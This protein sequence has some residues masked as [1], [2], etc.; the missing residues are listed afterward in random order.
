MRIFL[1]FSIVLL[2]SACASKPSIVYYSSAS[3]DY[4]QAITRK[5]LHESQLLTLQI[6]DGEIQQGRQLTQ[7]DVGNIEKFLLH[8][9][10][11]H[12]KLFI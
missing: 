11:K 12:Y 8:A 10:M 1:I 3:N 6:V 5:C 4:Q 7:Q 9:C 2:C